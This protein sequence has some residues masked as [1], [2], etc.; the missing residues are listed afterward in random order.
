MSG[1]GWICDGRGATPGFQCGVRHLWRRFIRSAPQRRITFPSYHPPIRRA[2]IKAR[3]RRR[4]WEGLQSMP[5]PVYDLSTGKQVA[6][7]YW[8]EELPEPPK[9][10][11]AVR[12][13]RLPYT[14]PIGKAVPK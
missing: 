1:A 6:T 13:K 7:A 5:E 14:E 12:T 3:S 4:G 2:R 11:R 9:P 10:K 8:P